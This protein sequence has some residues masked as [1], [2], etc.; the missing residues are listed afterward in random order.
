M[1][2]FSV[3]CPKCKQHLSVSDELNGAQIQCPACQFLFT[4]RPQA[5]ADTPAQKV[6]FAQTVLKNPPISLVSMATAAVTVM[7][8]VVYVL[9][10]CVK[11]SNNGIEFE[12]PYLLTSLIH[13]IQ[14]GV[15][16]LGLGE[17]VRLL[18]ELNKKSK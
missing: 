3:Y 4:A 5:F 2:D 10:S 1:A 17:V 8:G 9:K 15:L 14:F 13:W 6:S 18:T 11:L 12:H 7:V 16:L